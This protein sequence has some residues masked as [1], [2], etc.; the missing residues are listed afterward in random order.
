MNRMDLLFLAVLL[1]C[2]VLLFFA[3]FGS[4]VARTFGWWGLS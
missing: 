4:L 1:V 3:L 2:G